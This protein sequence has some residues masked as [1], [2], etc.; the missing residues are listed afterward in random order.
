VIAG[1]RQHHLLFACRTHP[2]PAVN[3]PLVGR[4]IRRHR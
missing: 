4:H 1:N 3:L 2:G